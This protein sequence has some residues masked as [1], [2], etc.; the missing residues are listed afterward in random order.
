MTE[1]RK[2]LTAMERNIDF[3]VPMVFPQDAEWKRSFARYHNNDALAN[4]RFRSW[5]T[6]ELLIRCVL[7]FMPWVRTIHVLLASESQLQPWMTRYPKVAVLCVTVHR[8][9]PAPH[10]RTCRAVRLC[11]R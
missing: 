5:G 8:D 6:E 4:V 11:Q 2:M 1:L 3:V 9:V 10:P 7:R